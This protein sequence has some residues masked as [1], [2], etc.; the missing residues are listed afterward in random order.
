MV[1]TI[2]QGQQ[3]TANVEYRDVGVSLNITPLLGHGDIITLEISEEITEAVD[4]VLHKNIS[5]S[6]IQTS[7]TNMVT[8]AHVPDGH[9][10]ILSGLTKTVQSQATTGPSCLGGI[11]FLASL[12]QKKES[13]DEKRNLLIFVRPHILKTSDMR[14]V[15]IEP[16]LASR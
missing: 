3:T 8:S 11:P 12:F 4:H 1:Q 5:L 15:G 2:G 7:K 10:L 9:F 13:R 6:G 16:P 14:G